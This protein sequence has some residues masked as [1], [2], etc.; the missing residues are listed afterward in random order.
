MH[1]AAIALGSNLSS[2]FGGPSENLDEAV[3]RIGALGRVS[4]VSSYVATAPEIYTDQPDFVNAALVLET[5][6]GP[7][8]LLRALLGIEAAMGRV[9]TGVPPKGPR[10]I[11]LD[12]IFFDDV[13]MESA[14]LV[15]PHPGLPER[16]FVLAPLAEIAGKWVHPKTG[17]TVAEML[18][19]YT[20]VQPNLQE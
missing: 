6:L 4:A 15:L 3:R 20:V 7:L 14:E 9:R 17:V 10:I 5:L 11:D 18:V 8:E 2:A 16:R 12:L 13:A 1:K 19:E